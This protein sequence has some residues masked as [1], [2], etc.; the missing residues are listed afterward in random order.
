M[1]VLIFTVSAAI[2][3]SALCSLLES[4]LY[5]TRVITLEAA[6][7]SGDRSARIMR[8]LKS[9]VDQP[10]AA[11]LTLNTAANTAGAAVAGWAAGQ[12]W[13][14]RWLWIFSV[15]FTLGI[16]FFSEI[17]P[18]TIGAIHWRRLW[19]WSVWPLEGMTW[20]LSPV[21]WL[22]QVI[23]G[24][25]QRRG[26]QSPLV[27][28]EE[29]LAAARLGARGGEISSLEHE[30]IINIVR[31]EELIARDIMTPRTV[32]QTV[33]GSRMVAEVQA[34][35]REWRHTR[36]PVYVGET[37]N[38]VGYVIK[39]DVCGAEGDGLNQM[40]AQVAMPIRFVPDT[41]NALILLDRFLRQREHIYLVVDEYGAIR[42][43]VT[44]ED[45]LE[46]LVGE[47]IVDE[48]DVVVDMQELARRRGRP[49]LE[50]EGKK[51][52]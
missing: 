19:P 25:I 15:A 23:T 29:L 30:L 11:I 13:G 2:I 50:D 36:I 52:G 35:A 21:I 24:L 20:G 34:E 44:L 41:T 46:S 39:E 14:P 45:V 27:S 33:E 17:I 51:K 40:L 22:T 43:L 47:E 5:S 49:V 28:E 42:G 4:V 10:L 38:V 9:Q 16:L 37:E 26:K 31:L 7:T 6:V 1:A 8:R 48:K 18:K 32:M 3:I 12:V